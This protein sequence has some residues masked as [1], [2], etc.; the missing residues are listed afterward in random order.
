MLFCKMSLRITKPVSLLILLS[1]TLI[2]ISQAQPKNNAT[3]PVA[4]WAERIMIT[5][6]DIIL[7][8]K[9]DTGAD[10]SSLNATHQVEFEKDGKTWVKFDVVNRYGKQ[11][12]L[13][14]PVERSAR[15]KRIGGKI[16]KRPVIRLMLCIG[17]K[18]MEADVNLIDRSD[19]DFQMLIGRSFLAGN[20][21][22]DPASMYLLDPDCT[23]L[24]KP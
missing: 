15:I 24:K 9:L 2:S 21:L 11:V 16:Q 20:A 10:N 1:L 13:E 18:F 14:R 12:T 4:G 19:F 3:K 5:P 6:G 22:V 8:A 17:S 23:E 7:H